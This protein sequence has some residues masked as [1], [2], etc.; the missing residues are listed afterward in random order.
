VTLNESNELHEQSVTYWFDQLR[1][2]NEAAAA[3]LWNRYFQQLAAF[4]RS[5]LVQRRVSDEEDLAAEVLQALC[6]AA[7]SGRLPAIESR[8]DLWRIL[9]SWMRNKITDQVRAEH[10]A[11]RGGGRVRGRSGFDHNTNEADAFAEI[12]CPQ[13]SA[14]TLAELRELADRLLARLPNQL[15]RD[16]AL[17]RMAGKTVDEL[18]GE[19]KIAP[20]TVE[21][22]LAII[23]R[24]WSQDAPP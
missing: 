16:L 1:A 13:P 6:R 3:E 10:A 15:L 21:R 24:V 11:K 8:Q 2:G 18:S 19:F 17:A 9:L 22:K 23:R 20:R 14:A 7:E 12:A 4:A 5:R